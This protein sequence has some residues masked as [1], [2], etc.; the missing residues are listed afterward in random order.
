MTRQPFLSHLECSYCKKEFDADGLHTVC[1][2]CGKPLLVRYELERAR[3]NLSR[4]S[5]AGRK[6]SMSRYW[7][8]LPVR[9]LDN[10]VSLG[11]G[12]TPLLHAERLGEQ[13]GMDNLFIKDEGL[14]PTGSF[15]ARGLCIA[16]SRARELGV[17]EVV[18][19]SAGNAAGAMSAYAAKA[20]MTAHVF[21][22]QDV[23]PLFRMECR[24]YGAKITLVDGLI[25]DCGRE[26]KK[27]ALK[28]GWFDLSTLKEPYRLEG[29]KTM[30]YELAEDF[31]WEL[32][33]VIVY[34]TGGGTG[35][36]GMWKAFSE[37][38]ELGWIGDKRPRMVAVQAEG[39]APIPRA[40]E[41][42]EEF[43][44][45]WENATTVAGG[46]CVPAAIGD[47]LILGAV[48]ESNGTATTV[49]DDALV[50]GQIRMANCEGIFPSPEG[51]A[52][53]AALEKLLSQGWITA[54]ERV[55]LFNTGTGL[56]Y[57]L[58]DGSTSSRDES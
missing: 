21:M 6:P 54:Y 12:C 55:L 5:L 3:G 2:E 30:G 51:G 18:I 29:K 10:V 11:E 33:D 37:M 31:D 50:A 38:E 26:A 1:P 44:K 15:K 49:S 7:E 4:E 28:S 48:R 36:I 19:A 27:R 13:L 58:E 52:T 8:M 41:S 40:F 45:P 57:P 20:G 23:P 46:I 39:C 56:K 16:I 9:N 22:P 24:A 53:L 34:P 35:L 32:P 43:A 47:F 17:K 42:G 25:T 14:N